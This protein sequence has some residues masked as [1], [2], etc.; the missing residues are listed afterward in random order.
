MMIL[1]CIKLSF[2]VCSERCFEVTLL[3]Q[4]SCLDQV[5]VAAVLLRVWLPKQVRSSLI[6][7]PTL[8]SPSA[9]CI[10]SRLTFICAAP[11]TEL[12]STSKL[13]PVMSALSCLP[14]AAISAR[15]YLSTRVVRFGQG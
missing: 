4:P 10:S 11:Q 9:L 15:E 2:C 14:S 12:L 3:A 5:T 13:I 8:T 6:L 1:S 7:P